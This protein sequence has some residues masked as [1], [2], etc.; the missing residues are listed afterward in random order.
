[1]A[2]RF[3]AF[4]LETAKVLP[5]QVTDLLA[6]RPLGIACAAAVVSDEAEPVTWHGARD[7]KPSPQMSCAEVSSIIEQLKSFVDKGYTLVTWNGLSFDFNI[8]AEESGL[9]SEC[10]ELALGHVDMMFHAVC[11]L[12]HYLSL[13]KAAEGL[14]IG[15]KTGSGS[16]A[17][18]MWAQGRYDEVLRYNVQDAKVTLEVAEESQRR[19]ELVWITA[20]GTPRSMPLPVGW[21][22]V[23][24]ACQ[25]ALPDTSW[26]DNPP[27]RQSF[28]TWLPSNLNS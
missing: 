19:G 8:L 26:M 6:H 10:A 15:G 24:D 25:I 16:D 23:R 28:M 18:A 7:G 1:M 4:D 5:T 20:R 27:S 11:Q 14:G 17:P 12:G 9:P 3:V 21:R 22:C 13:G 2:M